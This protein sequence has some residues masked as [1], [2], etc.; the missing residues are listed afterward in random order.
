MQKIEAEGSTVGRTYSRFDGLVLTL[1]F[2][3]RPYTLEGTRKPSGTVQELAYGKLLL[4]KQKYLISPL[5][6]LFLLILAA[7]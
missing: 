1:K 7:E 5:L 3:S 6:H 2:L 4:Q